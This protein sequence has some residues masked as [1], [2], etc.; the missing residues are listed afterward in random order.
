MVE[1]Y[2]L[3][4]ICNLKYREKEIA[5]RCHAWCEGHEGQCAP[6]IT[7]YAIIPSVSLDME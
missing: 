7:K 2:F 4:E 1:E 3:C 5:E 6:E